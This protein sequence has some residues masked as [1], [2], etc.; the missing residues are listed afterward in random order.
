MSESSNETKTPTAVQARFKEKAKYA[1]PERIRKTPA[2]PVITRMNDSVLESICEN[3]NWDISTPGEPMSFKKSSR[4]KCPY[5]SSSDSESDVDFD[6]W[7]KDAHIW[8]PEPEKD[9][10]RALRFRQPPKKRMRMNNKKPRQVYKNEARYPNF[11][12]A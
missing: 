8:T 7:M 10:K 12:K 9:H 4:K 11:S 2:A 1:T 6:S 3:K 5:P